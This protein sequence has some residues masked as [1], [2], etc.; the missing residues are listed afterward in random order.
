MRQH[1]FRFPIALDDD[2]EALRSYWLTPVP[3]YRFT[4]VSFLIDREGVIRWVHDGGEYHDLPG[5]AYAEARAAYR[6]LRAT[7]ELLL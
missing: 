3:D 2:W 5:P 7:I 1:G 6:S 4:S